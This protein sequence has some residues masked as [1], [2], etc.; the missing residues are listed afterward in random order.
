MIVNFHTFYAKQSV[1]LKFKKKKCY[2]KERTA[3]W[4]IATSAFHRPLKTDSHT[5]C[6]AHA[7]PLQCRVLRV[8]PRGRREYP[9]C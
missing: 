2:R 1:K 9:N 6:R 7:L 8:S 5:P 3:D 4:Y